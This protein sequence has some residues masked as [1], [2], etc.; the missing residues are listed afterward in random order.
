LGAG[1]L[2]DMAASLDRLLRA[3]ER[4]RADADADVAW[5][6]EAIARTLDAR[7]AG[8]PAT[9]DQALGLGWS[10][11]L[12][13][14]DRLLREAHKQHFAGLSLRAAGKEIERL[15][16]NVRSIRPEQ[17]AIDDPLRLIAEAAATGLGIPKKRHLISI[18]GVQN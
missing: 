10:E 16:R 5:L 2:S 13:Y 8:E 9:L 7:A 4:C 14:R 15:A 6:G 3:T 17:I 12:G 18:L 11:L 1:S